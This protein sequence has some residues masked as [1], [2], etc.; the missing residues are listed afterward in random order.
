MT[1]MTVTQW[2]KHFLDYP[3]LAMAERRKVLDLQERN[4]ILRK[5][6]LNC[7]AAYELLRENF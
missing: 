3:R 5:S 2:R 4:V 1:D 6:E 7:L